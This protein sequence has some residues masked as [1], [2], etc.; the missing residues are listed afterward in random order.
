MK[1][2]SKLRKR[3]SPLW[4]TDFVRRTSLPVIRGNGRGLRI[5]F[6]DSNVS[7]V[8]RSIER[9]VEDS[10]LELLHPGD[11]VYDLGANI[12]WYTLL[13]ARHVGPAGRVIAFEP[14]VTNAAYIA[15]NAAANE[16]DN[17]SVVPA[18]VS[19][20]DG[21]AVFLDK[22]PLVS[23]LDKD[24]DDAQAQRRASRKQQ[25]RRKI[26]VPVLSLDTWIAQTEQAPPT[27]V[28]IDIEG[29]E[30]GALR[31]MSKT[32]RSAKPALVIEPHGTQHA[33]ADVLDSLDYEH[34]PIECDTPTRELPW[35]A[36]ILAL[37]RRG[38]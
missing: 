14:K 27:V 11:S 34:R 2:Q 13:A 23:R 36:H 19:D 31:G 16:F 26:A 18:A 28:K 30:I 20:Q 22:G 35:G 5:R 6:G 3:V 9:D 29:A 38:A 4:L 15:W 1:A 37:P 25:T 21:W 12:G 7:R 32:L 17:V 10:F 24:D 8:I 33:V